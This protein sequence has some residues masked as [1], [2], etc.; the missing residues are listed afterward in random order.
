MPDAFTGEAALTRVI[1]RSSEV[2]AKALGYAP[3]GA[4]AKVSG[5]CA[6]CGAPIPA[7][8]LYSKLMLGPAFMDDLSLAARGSG[9]M[10]G[11]CSPLM[12]AA[13]LMSSG[14][15]AFGA[16]GAK[17]FRKWVDVA[18]ALLNP[19]E[20]PFVMVYA[21]ANNQ[22]MAWRAP[23]NL[24]RHVYFVRVGLRDL[25][26]RRGKVLEAVDVCARLAAKVEKA[27]AEAAAASGKKLVEKKG[28]ARKTLP[29]PYVSLTPDLKDPAHGQI[30]PRFFQAPLSEDSDVLADLAFLRALTLG[31]TWALRFVLTPA[32]GSPAATSEE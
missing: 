17:P 4:V 28:P 11:W 21:T 27:A 31:E 20:P 6:L 15:G 18:A 12:T 24:S 32:A 29:N 5:V 22:H 9:V 13:G 23:V 16:D 30:M 26:V 1:P 2:I 25:R 3:E 14:F 7:G 19:P 10:C 8:A